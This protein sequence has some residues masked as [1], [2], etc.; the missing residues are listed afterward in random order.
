MYDSLFP[1]R[2]HTHREPG[3]PDMPTF[4][5][6]QAV[7][8]ANPKCTH[9]R[10]SMLHYNNLFSEIVDVTRQYPDDMKVQGVPIRQDDNVEQP[11]ACFG[12]VPTVS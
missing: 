12:F 9:I 1:P 3:E 2:P 8:L 5:M 10:V 4:V 11:T 6:L 7:A